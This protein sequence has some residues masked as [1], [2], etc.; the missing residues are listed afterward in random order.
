MSDIN[1]NPTRHVQEKYYQKLFNE[2]GGT[3]MVVSSE[4]WA[5]K[6]IRFEKVTELMNNDDNFSVHDVGMGIADLYQ[7]MKKDFPINLL[8]ILEPK[9]S[10]NTMKKQKIDFQNVIFSFVT[11][12][13]RHLMNI[14]TI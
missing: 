12:Q 4:S 5:H 14:M 1:N 10:E 13:K 8:P 6:N 2:K 7:Y 3:T 9:Y 11:L